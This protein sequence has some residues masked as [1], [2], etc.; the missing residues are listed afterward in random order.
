VTFRQGWVATSG[1]LVFV[2]ADGTDESHVAA[3]AQA[4]SEHGQSQIFRVIDVEQF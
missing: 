3:A 4:W 1:D 2:L